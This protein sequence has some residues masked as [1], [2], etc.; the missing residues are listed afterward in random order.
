MPRSRGSSCTGPR[1]GQGWLPVIERIEVRCLAPCE[2]A[3]LS[4]VAPD[5]FDHQVRPEYLRAFLD[6]P[7]SHLAVAID[8]GVV[9]GMASGLVYGHPDKP[10][11]LF[12]NEVGVAPSHR[13]RGLG[14]ALVRCLLERGREVG[15]SEAWVAAKKGDAAARGLYLA[16]GGR[17]D[18]DLTV[19]YTYPLAAERAADDALRRAALRSEELLFGDAAPVGDAV[20]AKVL[21]VK[22]LVHGA[23]E[24][25]RALVAIE[26]E[27]DW[28][29]YTQER[30]LL[31]E[32]LGADAAETRRMVEAMRRRAATLPIRWFFVWAGGERVG[33]VGLMTLEEAGRLQDV[34]VFPRFRGRG[35]GRL[36][37]RAIEAEATAAGCR[38][39]VV[40][41]DHDDWPRRWY[42]RNGYR[43][44]AAVGRKPA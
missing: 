11:Q 33:A 6:D 41:A 34:D 23:D 9:V 13:R 19:V 29:A 12:V 44:V 28:A 10:L 38:L 3:R 31:E 7:C 21:L 37:L 15:C 43:A 1:A 14:R 2:G 17:E 32:G 36:L 8:D 22:R 5:V 39:L 25:R 30:A 26:A 4:A 18:G 20:G 27:R 40:G 35:L 42:E 24:V 16:A